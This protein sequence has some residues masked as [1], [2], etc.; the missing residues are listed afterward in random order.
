MPDYQDWFS[1]V[2]DLRERDRVTIRMIGLPIESSRGCWWGQK[3][4]FTFC[5]I[6]EA[7]LVYR[8]KRDDTVLEMLRELRE[9]HGPQFAFRFSDYILPHSYW[10]NLLPKL[11]EEN[12][13][14]VLHCEIK[15]N[16]NEERM[17]ALAD[18][19]FHAVQPGIESFDSNVLRLMKKGVTGIHNVYCIKL[20]Y[21]H[22]IY[23]A[24]N[25]LFGFP[26]E[27][28]E[29]YSAMTP[30]VPRLYH[31]TPPASRTEVIVTRFAP[32]HENTDLCGIR[33]APRHHRG[34][35]VLFSQEFLQRT[36][37]S[38]DD[39]AYYFERHYDIKPDVMRV[40]QSLVGTVDEWK[41][42]HHLR[43]VFLTWERS[44]EA[45]QE[46]A[47]LVIRDSRC[48]EVR[49]Y[50]LDAFQSRVYLACDGAPRTIRSLTEELLEPGSEGGPVNEALSFLDEEKL[51]WREG[52]QVLGLAVPEAI[53][54]SH[55]ET[56][57]KQTW[58]SLRQ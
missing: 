30:L 34:Y 50:Q 46:D 19:G 25:I 54:Q 52:D 2:A 41:R 9:R 26:G 14:W 39:Y 29:W 16:Q 31:L 48:G 24:Y 38:L 4:H 42:Q 20:G 51:I 7:T 28:A 35:D 8:Q 45:A 58:A 5:G 3:Q 13:P 37:F 6:D 18:A 43:E 1:D 27:R 53:A 44:A 55:R 56:G 40:H 49:E 15:A 36:G 11:A 47:G 33:S 32:L 17:K 12:P 21:L 10:Q 23:I 22:R 57:W